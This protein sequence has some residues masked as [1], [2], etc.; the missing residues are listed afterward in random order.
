MP[1]VTDYEW[2][3]K[4]K[5]GNITKHKGFS[6]DGYEA[7]SLYDVP[8][9]LDKNR[10]LPIIVSGRANVGTGKSTKAFQI[11]LYLAWRLAGGEQNLIRNER[12]RFINT[13][14]IKSP[15]KPLNFSLNNVVF[16]PEE[17]VDKAKSLPK[18]SVIIFDEGRQG[19]SSRDS[20]SA[21]NRLLETFFEECRV[22][23]HVIIIV[24]P[25]F[26]KLGEEIATARSMALIDCYEDE[27]F[28]RG[29]FAFFNKIQKEWLYFLGKKKLGATQKYFAAKPSFSGRFTSFFPFDKDKYENMKIE[30]LKKKT[31]GSRIERNKARYII[32][33]KLYKDLSGK[34]IQEIADELS[35]IM[36]QKVTLGSLEM[37]MKRYNHYVKEGYASDME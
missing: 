34:T 20:M 11:G 36:K 33:L 4:D 21:L 9:Y 32:L 18:R 5:K 3:S 14:I 24:L 15:D 31:L 22:L 37:D 35:N 8:K 26:F 10:D 12:G 6:M 28:N 30:A 27:N 25:N 23:N 2:E 16:S 1:I 17:L 7:E 13:K 29:Y 19:L